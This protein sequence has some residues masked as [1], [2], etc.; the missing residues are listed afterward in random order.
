ME[1]KF[2]Y[3]GVGTM[4]STVLPALRHN[5]FGLGWLEGIVSPNFVGSVFVGSVLKVLRHWVKFQCYSACSF[6]VITKITENT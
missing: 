6:S 4:W 2:C 3:H 1:L 5:N